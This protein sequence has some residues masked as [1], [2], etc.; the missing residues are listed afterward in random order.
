MLLYLCKYDTEYRPRTRNVTTQCLSH[1]LFLYYVFRDRGIA[2]Q[3]TNIFLRIYKRII[4]YS[5][6]N[7]SSPTKTTWHLAHKICWF[8]TLLSSST[9]CFNYSVTLPC[10]K[11]VMQVGQWFI[12]LENLQIYCD[13]L[14]IW[15]MIHV[16]GLSKHNSNYSTLIVSFLARQQILMHHH[17]SL[18]LYVIHCG[19]GLLLI[20]KTYLFMHHWL[21]LCHHPERWLQ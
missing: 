11:A 21:L 2:A 17:C 15:I 7:L 10:Q 8:Q 1:V 13:N 19:E 12:I 20:S 18:S 4:K 5:L 6:Q 3:I 16:N 9:Y 14:D